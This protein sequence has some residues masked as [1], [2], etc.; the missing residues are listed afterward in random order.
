[1]AL[2]HSYVKN[3]FVE[4]RRV[5]HLIYSNLHSVEQRDIQ[6]STLCG[7]TI[8]DPIQLPYGHFGPFCLTAAL[9]EQG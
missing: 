4:R 9:E 8:S 1:M 6:Q 7:S 3:P 5:M 2:T